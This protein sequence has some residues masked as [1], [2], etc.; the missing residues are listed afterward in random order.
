MTR[1]P[2]LLLLLVLLVA[3]CSGR[4]ERPTPTPTP[5]AQDWLERA[6]AAWNETESFHFTLVLADRTIALDESGALSFDEV[7][8]DVVAPD[9]LQADAKIQ[10]PFGSAE[11]GYIA[12]GEAQW[13]TNPLSG[14]WEPAPADFQTEV[15]G[16]FD[17]QA[18]IGPLLLDI[19]TLERLP[20]ESLDE[21]TAVR[22]R[23]TLPGAMLSAFASDLP[24]NVQV[25]L[26]IGADDGRIRQLLITE[27]ADSPPIPTWTFR[28][29]NFDAVP[30][31]EPPL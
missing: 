1:R 5:T 3:A 4:E 24:E 16:L 22:L 2:L 23:G 14:R 9:R 21:A 18:G 20:D 17:A 31:I 12:I 13:L 11:V 29:S 8:G 19:E 6:V 25:D 27:P 26:W 28:F 30:P 10:T 7:E 15:S